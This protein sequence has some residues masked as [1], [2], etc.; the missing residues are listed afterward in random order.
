MLQKE[1]EK[2]ESSFHDELGKT[3]PEKSF[4]IRISKE[5]KAHRG[6]PFIIYYCR[7]RKSAVYKAS[8]TTS[9]HLFAISV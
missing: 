4:H 9:I 7:M 1:T 3:A 5:K 2:T 6:V 8:P